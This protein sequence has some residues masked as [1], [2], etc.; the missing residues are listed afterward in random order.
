[1]YRFI[2]ALGID[3]IGIKTAKQLA[4]HFKTFENFANATEEELISLPDISNIIANCICTYFK[5]DA[6][7][8]ELSKLFEAGV[9]PK[10]LE[11]KA[12]ENQTSIFAGKKV[13][14]TGALSFS[15]TKATEMLEEAGAEVVSSVSK[16]TDFVV[17]GDDAGSKL[18]KATALGIKILNEQEFLEALKK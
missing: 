10:N 6:N 4:S 11:N 18:A 12:K 2:F 7:Q 15:R 13:V 16:N 17:A 9:K 3:N 5:T 1:M 14:L 8:I